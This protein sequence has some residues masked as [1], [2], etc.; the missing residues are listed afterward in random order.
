MRQLMRSKTTLLATVTAALVAASIAVPAL[1]TSFGGATPA[2]GVAIADAPGSGQSV[3]EWNRTLISILGTPNAQPATVHPTRAFAMLQAGEYNAVVSITHAGRPYGS[4]V[5]A[6][7]DA[8]PDAAAD[9]AAH[10]VLLGLYPSMRATLDHQLNTELAA[11]PAGTPT[12]DG[13]EVGAAAAHAILTQRAT[14]GSAI[15]P[16]LFKAGTAPG[17]YRPTP[18]KFPAPMYTRWGSVRLFVL[19]NVAEYL[20]PAPPQ[21]TSP[22]YTSALAE[23][24]SIGQDTSTTRTTDQTVA[25]KFWSASPIW[26]TWNQIA[27]ILSTDHHGSLSQTTSMFA[28]L[29]LALADTTI[30]LY[31][32]KYHDLIWRP[33]TAIQHGI[34]TAVPPISANPHWNPLT[35]TAA[36]PSYPGAHSALSTAAATVLT[37]SYGTHQPV[38]VTAATDPGVT[39]SF[40]SLDAAADEAGL[41]RIWAGQHTRLDHQA[42]QELGRQVATEV[43][44]ALPTRSTG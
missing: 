34:P 31:D 10:D 1:A 17:D 43:L 16:A 15:T 28:A 38:A 29:D 14:D 36:D 12:H 7:G 33:V 35:P 27:A 39:R 19:D 30:V 22:G 18:P 9:Q 4:A 44:T 42:G 25:G 32:A 11:L 2:P 6:A 5:P 20:P 24:K 23:V 26:N 40:P 8:R 41:S 3:A 13:V 21:V 37:A